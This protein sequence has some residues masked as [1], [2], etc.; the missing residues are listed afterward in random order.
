MKPLNLDNKP[1][2]PISSNCVIWQGPDIPCI[3]LCTG[4]TVSDVVAKLAEELCCILNILDINSYDLSCFNINQSKPED[5]KAFIQFLTEKICELENLPTTFATTGEGDD[6]CPSGCIVTVAEPFQE[7]DRTTMNLTEYSLAMGNKIAENIDEINVNKTAIANHEVRITGLETTPPPTF[8]LPSITPDCV[9]A[10]VPTP[11]D[12]VLEALESNYCIYVSNVGSVS[13][14]TEAISRE[15]TGLATSPS[16]S[17]PTNTMATE[18][19]GTWV[20]TPSTLAQSVNNLWITLCDLRDANVTTVSVVDTDTIDFGLTVADSNYE[21]TAQIQ[22]SGWQNLQ[23]FDYYPL[24]IPKPQVRKIGKTLQF[25]GQVFIPLSNDGG[26]TLI[27]LLA[28]TSY[29]DEYYVAPFTA[30]GGVTLNSNGA[31]SF[32]SNTS[33]IP[34]S[35]LDTSTFLDST[36]KKT[37]VIATRAI[38]L[39]NTYG[40]SLSAYGSVTLTPDKQLLFQV[41]KDLEITATNPAG[42]KGS[43]A[44]RFITSDVRQGEYVPDYTSTNTYIHNGGRGASTVTINAAGSGY[45]D[46]TYSIHL[47][48]GSG[49][50]LVITVTITAG[51]VVSVDGIVEVGVGYSNTDTGLTSSELD[52]LA[53]GTLATF[54]VTAVNNSPYNIQTEVR[55]ITWPFSC[56]AGEETDL[57]G[58]TFFLDGLTAYID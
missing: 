38:D 8:T 16:K 1:C 5:F 40:T 13:D 42:Y 3:N 6:D 4:D 43:S 35:V 26:A 49:K 50:G 9:L 44:L 23:G 14:V 22:D 25:R 27:P 31:I 2:S 33:V 52:N 10:G 30:A 28:A 57:G 34:T 58:F 32:N 7:D 21:I 19:V 55:D 11:I 36:Y 56:D 37:E 39:D 20:N 29:Y 41:L 12:Q 48:G 24:S 17:N 47:D 53:G 18:Y 46:G 54:N 51:A 15:C 45:T